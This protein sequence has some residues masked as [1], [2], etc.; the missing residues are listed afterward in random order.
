[1]NGAPFGDLLVRPVLIAAGV[2]VLAGFVLG[3]C[4]ASPRPPVVQQNIDTLKWDAILEGDPTQLL[5]RLYTATDA[6]LALRCDGRFYPTK[7]SAR[8]EMAE[9]PSRRGQMC[10]A[11]YGCSAINTAWDG[12]TVRWDC[13]NGTRPPNLYEPD[14]VK[15]ER[16]LANLCR[17]EVA[18][19]HWKD[20]PADDPIADCRGE[21]ENSCPYEVC[22]PDD[23]RARMK[24]TTPEQSQ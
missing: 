6:E 2:C 7:D 15:S 1:M 19:G 9:H 8:S 10:G 20:G 21:M 4:T 12:S 23:W 17:R 3:Q 14:P 24:A 5:D 11:Y 18:Q 13:L 22:R 16:W